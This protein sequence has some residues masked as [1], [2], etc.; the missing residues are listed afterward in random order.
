MSFVIAVTCLCISGCLMFKT[1]DPGKPSHTLNQAGELMRQGKF[2]EAKEEVLSRRNYRIDDYVLTAQEINERIDAEYG[3]WAKYS[4][5]L[6]KISRLKTADP[7][8]LSLNDIPSHEELERMCNGW[9]PGGLKNFFATYSPVNVCVE[10][11]TQFAEILM[12]RQPKE[13]QEKEVEAGRLQATERK[14]ESGPC[15]MARLEEMICLTREYEINRVDE[16]YEEG[17]IGR[18]SGVVDMARL[19]RAGTELSLS[20]KSLDR[21]L[22]DYKAKKSQDFDFSKCD[23]KGQLESNIKNCEL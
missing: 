7:N 10:A 22:K 15:K 12:L 19:H 6:Q 16:I 4:D 21:L 20:E 18:S 14:R 2:S 17:Q 5:V 23:D 11:A 3:R 1:G 9:P 13:Q 8:T